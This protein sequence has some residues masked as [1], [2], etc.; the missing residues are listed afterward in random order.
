MERAPSKYASYYAQ[1]PLCFVRSN[2]F[3]SMLSRASH[4]ENDEEFRGVFPLLYH[5]DR[6]YQFDAQFFQHSLDPFLCEGA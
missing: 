1:R 5:V 2:K 4:Y 3:R 6:V